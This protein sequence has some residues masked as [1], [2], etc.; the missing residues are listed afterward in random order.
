MASKRSRRQPK[1]A[2][3]I[4][5]GRARD[6]VKIV[7]KDERDLNT[8]RTVQRI[9]IDDSCYARPG[10]ARGVGAVTTKT[11]DVDAIVAALRGDLDV[12]RARD[13]NDELHADADESF[14]LV[15]S[16][17]EEVM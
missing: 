10:S 5:A 13:V 12:E 11:I 7:V 8:H 4:A 3:S 2:P 9:T 1:S 16:E 15:R 6:V 14:D 17:P